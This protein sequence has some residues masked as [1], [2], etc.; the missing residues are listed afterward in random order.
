[1]TVPPQDQ[2]SGG[3]RTPLDIDRAGW[4][5]TAKR[6]MKEFIRDRCTLTAASL[7][8]YWF[9]ALFPALIALLGLTSLL[10][11]STSAVQHLVNGLQKALPQGASAVFGDA[12][13]T[14]V[15]RSSGSL[16][17]VIVG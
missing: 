12:V 10:H 11:L 4:R 8:Y 7:A 16:T 2:V 5:D 15:T 1:M 6:T 9:L 3:P 17:A 13:T 14:A